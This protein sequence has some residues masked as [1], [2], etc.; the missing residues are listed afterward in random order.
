MEVF[1]RSIM[2]SQNAKLEQSCSSQYTTR[3]DY[4]RC[5]N[6][7]KYKCWKKIVDGSFIYDVEY[8]IGEDRTRLVSPTRT[9]HEKTAKPII[10]NIFGGSFAFGEGVS[11]DQTFHYYLS[12]FV[13]ILNIKNY[14][15]HGYGMHNALF[16]LENQI[17][18]DSDVNIFLTS[19]F[20]SERSGCIPKYV[21][22]H[23]SYAE[24]DAINGRRTKF[25]GY[26]KDRMYTPSLFENFS[27]GLLRNSS[28]V[29]YTMRDFIQGLSSEHVALYQSIISDLDLIT[30]DQGAVPIFVYLKEKSARLLKAGFRSDPM[31]EFFA[32]NDINSFDATLGVDRSV[33]DARLYLH[34]LDKHPSALA[35]CFRAERL[36]VYLKETN[37]IDDQYFNFDFQCQT[38]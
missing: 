31:P 20:H 15:F 13:P 33:L 21:K 25:A 26:C 16:L 35:N 5:P 29:N 11:D 34:Q 22:E 28:L 37:L 23:P 24:I 6:P 1:A 7:G 18:R 38:S 14:S 3:C 9:H 2:P 30:K 12:N 32:R 8:N 17:S 36:A 4:G 27:Q 10:M 19:A